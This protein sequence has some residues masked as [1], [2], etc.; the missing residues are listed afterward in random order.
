MSL[1]TGTVEMARRQGLPAEIVSA[2]GTGTY[3][4]AG[5][6]P[7]VTEVQAGSY[8]LMDLQYRRVRKEFQPALRIL[9]T[10]I[11]RPS[12]TRAVAD[13]GLK[14][15]STEFGIPEAVAPPGVRLQDLSEEHSILEV[16]EENRLGPGDRVEFL[17]S[18]SCTTV[19]LHPCMFVVQEGLVREVWM[20]D[21]RR[22]FRP[23]SCEAPRGPRASEGR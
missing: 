11:S 23:Q 17:P 5:A 21:G 2:G 6:F 8:A 4:V 10:V 7:G 15:L 16:D 18:H 22:G 3:D 1:L 20:I 19:P 14:S 9:S 12:P 13:A